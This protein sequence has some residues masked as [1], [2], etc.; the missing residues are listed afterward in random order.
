[1]NTFI[2]GLIVG[3]IASLSVGGIV[4]EMKQRKQNKNS[5]LKYA[6]RKHKM[7]ELRMKGMTLERIS[8][9]TGVPVSTVHRYVR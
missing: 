6:T 9:R 1:M 7:I 4:I 8:K 3:A 2:L 5:R